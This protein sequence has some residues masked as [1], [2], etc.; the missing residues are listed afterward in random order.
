MKYYI[1][2][3][4]TKKQIDKAMEEYAAEKGFRVLANRAAIIADYPEILNPSRY[5]L[6]YDIVYLRSEFIADWVK[7]VLDN[8]VH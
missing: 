5:Y 4:Y 7:G 6:C 3:V 1:K 2:H 8:E